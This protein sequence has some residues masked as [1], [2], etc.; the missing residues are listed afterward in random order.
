MSGQEELGRLPYHTDA[1]TDELRAIKRKYE[2]LLELVH[3][4]TVFGRETRVMLRTPDVDRSPEMYAACEKIIG[5]DQ[6]QALDTILSTLAS[7]K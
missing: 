2:K 1:E 6:K 4:V 3:S 5:M 7:P